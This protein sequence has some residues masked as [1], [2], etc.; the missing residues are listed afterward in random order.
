M[1]FDLRGRGRR[2][3][4]QAVYLGLALLLGIGLVGFGIGGG[5]FSGGLFNAVTNSNSPS[6]SFSADVKSAQRQTRVAP[7]NPAGWAALTK[8]LYQEAGT[9][10]NFNQ[11]SNGFTGSGKA[12]LD[13]A[14]QAW[15]H[16]LSLTK[17][18]SADLAQFMVQ[19]YGPNGLSQPAPEVQALQIVIAANPNVLAYYEDLAVA[20]YQAHNADVGD[21]ASA[22]AVS[23]APAAQ[24]KTLKQELAALKANPSGVTSSAS[25]PTSTVETTTLA[26]STTAASTTTA[27]TSSGSKSTNKG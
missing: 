13:Q 14:A 3:T 20:A 11:A 16:Y 25:Q 19:A 5:A 9:G 7:A 10:S 1:L 12:V 22:K 4:V 8:A 21:L 17:K 26:T 24:Q 6:S 18:P 15:Q 23:L 2:R 27:T